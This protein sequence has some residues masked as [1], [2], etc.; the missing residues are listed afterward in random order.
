MK[1]LLFILWHTVLMLAFTGTASAISFDR[2]HSQEEIA[3]YLRDI[4]ANNS[5]MVVFR[6]LGRS[7]EGREIALLEIGTGNRD[8]SKNIYLN[9]T[10]HGNERSSTESTLAVIDYLVRNKKNALIF[11]LLK[12]YTFYIQPLVNPD[13]HAAGTREESSGRDLNRDYPIP[14]SPASTGFNLPETKLIRDLM[15]EILFEGSIAFHSGM[16]GVLW[17]WCHSPLPTK[18]QAV[19]KS[20]SRDVAIAMNFSMQKQSWSD[21]PTQG[22]FTDY[23]YEAFGTYGITIEVSSDPTPLES[24]LK[25]IVAKAVKGTLAF[26]KALSYGSNSKVSF[27]MDFW[28]PYRSIMLATQLSEDS[29]AHH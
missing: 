8:R 26:A 10:H 22:E 11:K 16:E 24:K 14:G 6:D 29:V 2:Y 21:Y 1:Q 15:K 5:E 13:G 23:A 19:F 3:S 4:A 25:Q 27:E 28:T 12:E 18:H 9:G 17:P 7:A 20:L